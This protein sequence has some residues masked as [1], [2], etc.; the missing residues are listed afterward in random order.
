MPL[1]LSP[2]G[3]VGRGLCAEPLRGGREYAGCER[4]RRGLRR[5]GHSGCGRVCGLA[6]AIAPRRRAGPRATRGCMWAGAC[7]RRGSASRKCA[8][9]MAF[10]WVHVGGLV[11]WLLCGWGFWV[12]FSALLKAATTTLCNLRVRH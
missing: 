3:V 5:S 1:P 11:G 2:L 6:A 9:A 7:V 4:G 10:A 8:L 12:G